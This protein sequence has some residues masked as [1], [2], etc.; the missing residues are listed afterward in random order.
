MDGFG[1]EGLLSDEKEVVK[2]YLTP[3]FLYITPN[4]HR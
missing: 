2:D 4:R 1:V 3:T